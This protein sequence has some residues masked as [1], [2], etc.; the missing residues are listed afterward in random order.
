MNFEKS[1]AAYEEKIKALEHSAD[2]LIQ[3]EHYDSTLIRSQRDDVMDMWRRLKNLAT[4]KSGNLG[5][6]KLL[7][8]FLRN[9][10]EVQFALP[11][12]GAFLL[13]FFSGL[14]L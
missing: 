7:F 4:A 13:R 8:Q 2:Q 14:Y 5:E 12:V 3:Q 1:L 10:K 6:S 11:V 9:A